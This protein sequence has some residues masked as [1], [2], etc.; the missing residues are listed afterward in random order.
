[1]QGSGNWSLQRR[2]PGN[3]GLGGLREEK[4]HPSLEPPGSPSWRGVKGLGIEGEGRR[5]PVG[6]M[7]EGG[8]RTENYYKTI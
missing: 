7:A 4:S 3:R 5:S 2:G 6:D 8:K 1:M